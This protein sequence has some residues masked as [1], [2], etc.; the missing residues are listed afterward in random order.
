MT[1][2]TA[3]AQSVPTPRRR[4]PGWVLEGL[5]GEPPQLTQVRIARSPFSVGRDGAV[6][7]CLPSRSVSKR[8]AEFLLAGEGVLV[9]DCAS[10]NGTFVNGRR[11]AV[12]MPVGDGD[13]IAF[14][15]MEFRLGRLA[16]PP[17]EATTVADCPE[18]GWLISRL[19]DVINQQRFSMVFQPIVGRDLQPTGVEALIRGHIEGLES[20]TRLFDA[21]VRVGQ[22]QCLSQLARMQSVVA[23]GSIRP[24]VA[25]FFNTHPHERLDASLLRSLEVLRE[26]ASDRCLVL[27]VHEGAVSAPASMHEFRNGLRDLGIGLAYDDFGAGQSRLLELTRTPPDYLKFDRSLLSDIAAA[28]AAQRS[29]IRTLLNVCAELSIATVAEGLEDKAAVDTCR[30]LGFTHFQGYYFSRPV[31]ASA[32]GNVRMG[33]GAAPPP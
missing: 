17:A 21:A 7:C 12:P 18:G 10:T 33:I 26:S 24:D 8:H 11:I 23:L 5:L 3:I 25:L 13:L 31:A 6:D 1:R 2:P 32:I 29:L 20:P 9:R 19:Q 28:P 27:E 14:S 4:L 30:E 16:P 22:E 15:D